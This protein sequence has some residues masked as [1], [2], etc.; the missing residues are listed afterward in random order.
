MPFH[1][2]NR[3]YRS[4]LVRLHPR[5]DVLYTGQSR[6]VM[7]TGL[8]GQITGKP[9]TG[10]FV[11]ETRLLSRYRYLIQGN[12]PIPVALSNCEQHNWMGYYIEVPPGAPRMTDS[13]SGHVTQASEQTLELRVS[14]HVGPGVHEDLDLT[15]FSQGTTH[16]EFALELDADFADV[17][18][19][20]GNRQQHGKLS[21]SWMASPGGAAELAFDYRARHHYHHQGNRGTA[22]LRRGLIV[23]IE[24]AGSQPAFKKNKLIF[25]I[26][27]GPRQSWHTCIHLIP[28]IEDERL[29]SQYK[30][31]SFADLSASFD[32]SRITFLSESAQFTAPSAGTLEPVVLGALNQAKRDLAALRL[33]DLDHSQRAWT[34]AAGLPLYIALFGRDTLSASWQA[35]IL[36]PEMMTGTLLEL[37]KWQGKQINRWRDEEPGRMLHEAHT[38]P[39]P[40]LCY[41][42]RGRYY[43]SATTS[44][45]YPFAVTE[46]WHWTGDKALVRPLIEPSLRAMAWKE[47]RRRK[48][49]F[50][51]YKT[52]SEQGVKNQSWKDSVDAMVYEDGAQVKAPIGTCE[53]QAFV[54][55]GKIHMAELLWWFDE[56][57]KAKRFHREAKELKKRF[58]DV[59]WM[60]DEGFFAM[61]LDGKNRLIRSISSN[62]GH[63][64]AAGIVDESL[65][66]RTARR[67]MADDLFTGWGVRTLSSLHPAYNP[68]SYHRGSVWPVEQAAFA[69]GFW[70]YGLHELV[71]TLSKAVFE[72]AAFFDYYRLPEAVSGHQRD[73]DHPFPAV[74]PK[75]NSPQAW[76]ASA[77]FCL[78]QALLGIYPYAPL[79]LLFV[80]PHMPEW[81]PTITIDGLRVGEATV[82]LR[83]FRESNG[84]S[85][86]EIL[87]QRGT[88]HVVRQPSPW[89]LTAGYGERVRDL[90]TSFLPGK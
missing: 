48:G 44:S 82:S 52:R 53:E 1:H 58:N 15:N 26:K 30:C 9:D 62:P 13:G 76:S 63:C 46:L 7:A 55:I 18:E 10:L 12:P 16:F 54:Y 72:A 4:H 22:S 19:T 32:R 61:G 88:L 68:F 90:L 20:E 77:V 85:S 37:A 28:V 89:S 57:E 27:L 60:E 40:S 73:A 6:T 86:Y 29:E 64:I 39:I 51:E 34:M 81:L 74:Y 23:Q 31:R 70:R 75:A 79:N 24:N 43:G 33:H 71:E 21:R 66:E 36:G 35:S 83:F 14:R 69:I 25:K 84:S 87:D 59:F 3:G 47:T 8:D 17:G 50:Y 41:D 42:P 2:N 78:I 45:F 56:K 65:I 5:P 67:L 49:G 80:D 38:G 11:H